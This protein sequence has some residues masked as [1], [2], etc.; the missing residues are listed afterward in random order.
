VQS[1]IFT[2]EEANR[3]LPLGRAITQDAVAASR[4]A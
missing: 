3:A 2:L 1:A 4:A